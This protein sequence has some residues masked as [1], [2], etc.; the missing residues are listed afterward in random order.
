MHHSLKL[1][2]A[3]AL[4]LALPTAQ[5]VFH[6]GPEVAACAVADSDCGEPGCGEGV[7]SGGCQQCGNFGKILAST[8]SGAFPVRQG[9]LMDFFLAASDLPEGFLPAIE[10]P[11]RR[12]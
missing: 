2:F 1:I 6:C 8:P 4:V 9:L 5:F 3:V 12:G 10:Q 7:A 11:P